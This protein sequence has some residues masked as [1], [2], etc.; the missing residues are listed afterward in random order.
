MI[1]MA[2]NGEWRRAAMPSIM[3]IGAGIAMYS[4]GENDM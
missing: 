3:L 1:S 2:K 4:G